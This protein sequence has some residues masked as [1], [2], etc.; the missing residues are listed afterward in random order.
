MSTLHQEN[1][2]PP[3]SIATEYANLGEYLR[4]TRVNQGMDLLAVAGDTKISPKSLQAMEANDFA[5][6]PSEAFT[7]GFYTL[8]AKKLSI[9]FEEVLQ[10]Y[11]QQRP[12]RHKG[13]NSLLL[14]SGKSA[15]EVGNM[16]ERHTFRPVSFLG[17]VLMSLLFLG[18]FLCWYFS[19][20]PATYLSQKLRSLEEP[21]R[22]EQ[23][24]TNMTEP[25]VSESRVRFVQQQKP[26]QKHTDIFNLSY[27]TTATAAET[28]DL[29]K[30][31]VE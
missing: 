6:L 14:S 30:D 13:V 31:Q 23:V 28:L 16:A 26:A 20:N 21:Q 19:W 17:L 7:R 10:M 25:D 2:M 15:Q 12:H 9:D 1:I 5:A 27:P 3:Q 11:T 24:S 4:Q 8:Y 29:P 22:I 18:G